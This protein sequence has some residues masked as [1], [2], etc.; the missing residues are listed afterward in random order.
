MGK[1]KL[2]LVFD[3][4]FTIIFA[5]V[6]VSVFLLDSFALKGKAV[7]TLF[8]CPSSAKGFDAFSFSNP[9]CYLRIFFHVIGNKDVLI[10]LTNLM[11]LFFLAPTM[12]IRYGTSIIALM[13]SVCSMVSG[14]FNACVFPHPTCG[15]ESIVFLLIFLSALESVVK[16]NWEIS[17]ILS[18]MAYIAFV[19]VTS[20]RIE[21]SFTLALLYMLISLVG[22]I[23]GALI[24][25]LALPKKVKE[26][27]SDN[28]KS[29]RTEKNQTE[30]KQ[31]RPRQKKIKKVKLD[32]TAPTEIITGEF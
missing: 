19:L 10:F 4:P 27:K 31:K 5:A 20:Y 12:E 15:A 6:C 28:E 29:E 18:F 24:G 9:L 30:K 32:E 2:K 22:G 26:K 23:C 3:A 25:F 8:S 14:V 7:A 16:K 17:R 13:I 11:A 21:N 1:K